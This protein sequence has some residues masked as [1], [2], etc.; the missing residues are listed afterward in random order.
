[1]FPKIGQRNLTVKVIDDTN[2]DSIF[3][4]FE[5]SINVNV[6]SM[7]AN[8]FYIEKLNEEWDSLRS[9]GT[10][11]PEF[12]IQMH[13]GFNNAVA[14][15]GNILVKISC[16]DMEVSCDRVIDPIFPVCNASLLCIFQ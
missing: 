10:F 13:D 4:P 2:G 9:L 3:I 15:T 16:P 12:A 1:M 6:V 11:F 7:S 5:N 14:Y 8:D